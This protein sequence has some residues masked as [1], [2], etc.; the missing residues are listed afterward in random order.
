MAKKVNVNLE[1]RID[2]MIDKGIKGFLKVFAVFSFG[3][4]IYS[5]MWHC[6]MFAGFAIALLW[7]FKME[8]GK[9][10]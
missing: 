1:D 8:D 10:G 6:F 7:A 5:G 2:G 9:D 4:G 3:A